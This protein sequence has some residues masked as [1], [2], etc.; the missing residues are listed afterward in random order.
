MINPAGDESLYQTVGVG[1]HIRMTDPLGFDTR[2]E[3]NGVNQI[4][5]VIDP[6]LQETRLTYDAAQRPASIIDARNVTL[7]SYQYDNGDR[8]ITVTDAL[9]KT[10]NQS[11]TLAYDDNGNLVSKT[12]TSNAANVTTYA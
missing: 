10:T 4:T 5:K 9:N 6:P 12:E 3:Y 7:D 2:T 11:H 1:R 8:L